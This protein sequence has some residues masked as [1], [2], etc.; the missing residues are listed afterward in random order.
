MNIFKDNYKG[1]SDRGYSVIPDKYG[2]KL[3]AI[4]GWSNYCYKRPSK[5]EIQSWCNISK[6]NIALCLGEASGVVALDIDETR[7][8]ILDIIMPMLPPSPVSKVG[9]KGETRFFRFTGEQSQTLKYN[10]EMVVEI[11]SGN[12]KTTLPPSLHPAGVN[13]KWIDTELLK[14]DLSSL[15]IL[16]PA[17]LAHVESTLRVHIPEVVNNGSKGLRSGRN[18]SLSS[19]CGK[20]IQEKVPVDEAIKRLILFDQDNTPPLFGD[21]EE[22]MHTEPYSNALQFY[23]NHLNSVNSKRYRSGKE[24]EIP[25]TASAITAEIA[26]ESLKGKVLP[27][28][29]QRKPKR[30][31]PVALGVLKTIRQ[32]ILDNAWVKQESF[33]FSGALSLLATLMSRKFTFQGM[34][35][36]LYV[37]NIAPSGAGK[38]APQQKLKEYLISINADFLLGAGDYVSDASLM[39]GLGTK[40]VR[41]DI[42]DEAG[43][44]LKNVNSGKSEYNG[45]MADILAELYTSSNSKYLGRAT[46]EGTKGSC[47]RPN[48]NIM[49][50]TTPTGFSDGV[51]I[52]AIEKGLMGR[53]LV[54]QGDAHQ[55]AERLKVMPPL[56]KDAER[57]LR[58]LHSYTPSVNGLNVIGGIEQCV[59]ELEATDGANDML[60][61]VF[62]EFDDLRRSKKASDPLLPIIARLYQQMVKLVIIHAGSRATNRTPTIS[63]VDITFGYETILYYY[64]QMVIIIDRYI[65]NNEQERMNKKVLDLIRES[66]KITRASLSRST[67]GMNSRQRQGIIED[68]I[69]SEQIVADREVSN[70]RNMTVYI[71]VEAK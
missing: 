14:C 17:L 15:P 7:Q 12:K 24:Y 38:D 56:P 51:S 59:T 61:K 54:F 55:R 43:G 37:L 6:T 49:A 71:K 34:S 2:S 5:E 53:F 62:Y 64:D 16:P 39:D 48:V 40:P 3:P 19:E 20:L 11:L 44:V 47:Y 60:D 27:L 66:G 58:W 23:V 30:E 35:P 69:D 68:L 8:E 70:G 9:A 29:K 52:K 33:A 65:F 22:F 41:L 18:D 63:E 31:L 21:P 26:K 57:Q 13:Y 1:Y 36:N 32:N 4:K 46:A 67:R 28:E 50:S 45:K 25:I 10:G 42:M